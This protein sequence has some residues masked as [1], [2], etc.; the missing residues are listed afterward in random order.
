VRR[1]HASPA[2]AG[3][4]CLAIAGCGGEGGT[5]VPPEWFGINAQALQRLPTVDR[6]E[7]MELH[8]DASAELGVD[9]VRT[10]LDWRNIEPRAP[11]EGEHRYH[12]ATTDAWVEALAER[13]LRWQPTVLGAPTP[14]WAIDPRALPE[15]GTASP[16]ARAGDYARLLAEL[17]RRYGRSGEFW[18]GHPELGITPITHYEVWNE[19]NFD[20]FW[21]PRPQ[22]AKHARLYV[23]ARDAVH[24]VDR[25]ARVVYGGLATF[26]LPRPSSGI[27][28]TEAPQ[29]LRA[30]LAAE[31]GLRS[32]IDVVAMHPYRQTPDAVVSAIE[33]FRA[34]LDRLGLR[35]VPISVNEVG[36]VTSGRD[37]GPRASEDERAEYIGVTT[38]AIAGLDYV[39]AFAPHT[40]ISPELDPT[41]AEDWYGIADPATADPYPT[42]TAYGERIDDLAADRE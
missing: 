25:E 11:R 38:D 4:A 13:G 32:R 42:A 39:I 5:T 21:C 31:P 29:Y 23:A 1:R 6:T 40:W 16:P 18:A 10:N 36:W 20:R 24:T 30:A 7:E 3:L 37:G 19:Q 15:C 17:A 28:A 8:L 34:T 27:E 22:P 35:D 33:R 26:P 2:A 14:T 12:W 41:T 9:F